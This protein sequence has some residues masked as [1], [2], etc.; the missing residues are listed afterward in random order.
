MQQQSIKAFPTALLVLL[1]GLNG[2]AQAAEA[3]EGLGEGTHFTSQPEPVLIDAMFQQG[4]ADEGIRG[5]AADSEQPDTPTASA[6]GGEISDTPSVTPAMREAPGALSARSGDCPTRRARDLNKRVAVTSFTLEDHRGASLGALADFDG[7]L[8]D[9]LLNAF[10]GEDRVVPYS[11]VN[12]RLYEE[13]GVAPTRVRW[14]RRLTRASRLSQSMGVQFVVSGVIR[15]I[16]VEDPGAWGSSMLTQL[17]RGVGLVNLKRRLVVDLYVHDGFTGALLL[18]QR[19]QTRGNWE[20]QPETRVDTRSA[21]FEASDY[22]KQTMAL[23]GEMA[24]AV[25]ETLRCQPFMARIDRVEDRRILIASGTESGLEPGDEV[26]LY[27]SERFL[28]QSDKPPLL[29][30][31]G[32]TMRVE[33]V[34]SSFSS[35]TLP[36]QG[37][38]MNIQRGDRV[39]IW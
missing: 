8:A 34:Q 18:E 32:Q 33:R 35:G 15:D 39:V 28:D 17:Q 21:V 31:I 1:M 11:A 38:R 30:G 12:R 4:G 3:P 19:F 26:A 2:A 5:N 7:A 24:D 29:Q 6:P 25:S 23:V 14:D 27:R 9:R 10:E 36:I 13:P 16:S 22:G 20:F 37:H